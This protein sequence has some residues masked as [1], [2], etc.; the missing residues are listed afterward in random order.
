M[1]E[2]PSR[3]DTS[4]TTTEVKTAAQTSIKP[5]YALFPFIKPYRAQLLLALLFLLVSAGAA[6]VLPRAVGKM[7][8]HGFSA[9]DA[10]FIDQ[11]FIVLFGVA[12]VLAMASAARFYFVTRLGE[13]VIADLRR[14]VYAHVLKQEQAFFETTKSGELL[15]RLT[16]DTELVQTLIGSGISVALRH[17]LMLIGSIILLVLASPRLSLLIVIG[18][19]L[20]VAPIFLIGRRVQKLSRESQD[21]IAATSGVAGEAL[22]AVHTVQAFAREEYEAQRYSSAVEALFVAAKQRIRARASLIGVVILVVFGAITAV[23]WAGA[24][25]VLAGTMTGG[26]LT[27]FVLYAVVAAGATGALTEVWGDVQ[28]AAGSMGRISEL[29]KRVPA[30]DDPEI[31]STSLPKLRGNVE[32]ANVR[33][34]YPSRLDSA[35]IE[36]LDLK[37]NQGETVALVGRSG[38]GKSTLFQLLLRFYEP[39]SGTITIQG[40]NI[41]VMPL[42]VLRGSIALVPQDPVIFAGTIASNIA[43]GRLNATAAEIQSAAEM[44][45]AMEFIQKL[46]NGLETEVGERGVRLSGGQQQRIA[47]ARAILKDAPIL[48]L[49]EATSALDAQSERAVQIALARLMKGRTTLVI[50]HRLATVVNADRIIVLDQGRVIDQGK[51]AELIVREGLYAELAR[52]QFAD[53]H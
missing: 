11:Y 14:G 19:P 36:G 28:R 45:E 5:L 18:I 43:Y 10:A 30:I 1:S 21:R 50:A 3:S 51:H 37:V 40:T 44:A 47:I 25:S 22:N 34:H 38:A 46:P 17:V 49:D 2:L 32:F 27:Q 9:A 41:N 16:T 23:I 8:D 7:I 48:L 31:P 13:R 33:F 35:A 15:S 53:A 12:A 29:L 52:L 6:L 24:K 4:K 26:E 20:V 39:Q 42:G